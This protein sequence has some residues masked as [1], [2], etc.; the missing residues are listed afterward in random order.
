ME[1]QRAA[2]AGL[3][4]TVGVALLAGVVELLMS[5]FLPGPESP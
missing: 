1:A 4:I 3:A 2:G 5:D